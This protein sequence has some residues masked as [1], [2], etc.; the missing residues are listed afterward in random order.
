MRL[1]IKLCLSL[2]LLVHVVWAGIF[3]VNLGEDHGKLQIH[4]GDPT[5]VCHVDKQGSPYPL[6]AIMKTNDYFGA[7]PRDNPFTIWLIYK[8]FGKLNYG[9]SYPREK[10]IHDSWSE[11]F[12]TNLGS[13]YYFK[14][15]VLEESELLEKSTGKNF[16][17]YDKTATS[18][19]CKEQEYNTQV[20][21][22]EYN[23]Q[24]NK[25]EY[26]TQVNKQEYEEKM[27]QVRG[28]QEFVEEESKREGEGRHNGKLK[29]KKF[30]RRRG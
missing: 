18:T 10:S 30:N 21:K 23:T 16:A 9:I 15:H 11:F 25:Q 17:K 8:Q 7:K 26:N 2:L 28:M 24:V 19:A 13:H 27:N 22:Q 5:T 29:N 3:T 14:T 12:Y 20:N 4:A 1:T 6:V